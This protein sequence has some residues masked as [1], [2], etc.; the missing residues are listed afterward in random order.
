[1][2]HTAAPGIVLRFMVDTVRS[3]GPTHELVASVITLEV[4]QRLELGEKVLALGIPDGGRDSI[5]PCLLLVFIQFR[6]TQEASPMRESGLIVKLKVKKLFR[7]HSKPPP[8]KWA[9]KAWRRGEF[10]FK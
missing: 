4:I 7:A 2:T 8:A 1:M 5:A 6:E 10:N 3:R 9:I